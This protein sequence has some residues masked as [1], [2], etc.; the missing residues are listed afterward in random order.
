MAARWPRRAAFGIALL[1]GAVAVACG[2]GSGSS[3]DAGAAAPRGDVSE[4]STG[5]V[6]WEVPEQSP[7]QI[8]AAGLEVL[9]E[10][11]SAQHFHTHLDVIVD[12]SPVTV[13]VLGL[14]CCIS[15]LHTHSESGILHVES[16]DRKAAYTLGHLFG[17][18]GVRLTDACVGGYCEPDAEVRVYV[19]GAL[20]A[21]APPEERLTPGAEIAVVVGAAPDPVPSGYDCS[22]ADEIEQ[23]SCRA[24]FL[25]RS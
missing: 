9:D 20:T 17:L 22:T 13:P 16:P 21:V 8:D 18:W 23:K 12:G 2:G 6:P 10:E 15:P 24:S 3:D 11:G 19:D 5:P 25:V 1:L 4:V 7:A 14:G